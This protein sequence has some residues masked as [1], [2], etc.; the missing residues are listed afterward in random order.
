MFDTLEEYLQ[1]S[2][3]SKRQMANDIQKTERSIRN[4]L[5]EGGYKV[6]YDGRTFQ[7]NW[8]TA[9][10]LVYVRGRERDDD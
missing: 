4:W 3:K 8:I 1:V 10:R 5:S 6:D 2:R 7:V 9:K